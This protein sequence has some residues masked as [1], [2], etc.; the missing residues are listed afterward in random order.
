MGRRTVGGMVMES[1]RYINILLKRPNK[2]AKKVTIENT[3]EEMQK[4]VEG[5]IEVLRYKDA[6]LVCNEEGKLKDLEPNLIIGNDLIVGSFF[7]VGDDYKNADFI[8]LTEK[9]FKIFKQELA[10]EMEIEKFE[11]EEELI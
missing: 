8:S 11:M 10:E 2:R 5:P 3:L 6:L 9:Q 4:L 7:I 1:N